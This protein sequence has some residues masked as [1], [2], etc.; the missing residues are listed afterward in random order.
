V[1]G[2]TGK[3]SREHLPPKAAFNSGTFDRVT[4]DPYRTKSSL[5]FRRRT[6][7]GGHSLFALCGRCNNDTG[8]WY[9]AEYVRLAH[10]CAPIATQENARAIV[11]LALKNFY[12]LRAIKQVL[13]MASAMADPEGITPDMI[14]INPNSRDKLLSAG[15][16]EPDGALQLKSEEDRVVSILSALRRTVLDRQAT[17][18]PPI[19]RIHMFL[20]ANH[21]ARLHSAVGHMKLPSPKRNWLM[22][23]AYWPIGWIVAFHGEPFPGATDVTH[24]GACEYDDRKDVIVDLPC[25]WILGDFPLDYRDPHEL[26]E[27]AR[28]FDLYTR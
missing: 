14:V 25:Q 6:V 21:A 13:T 24:W 27:I 26:Y 18:F 5:A 15:E 10:A 20:V 12:P 17:S 7:Q 23:L 11:Q 16:T 2:S 28:H 8:S 1:S 9:G 4:V 19:V 3:L 22:E